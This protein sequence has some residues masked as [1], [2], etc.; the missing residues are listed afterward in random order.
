MKKIQYFLA[1]LFVVTL[2]YSGCKKDDNS[3]DSKP[4]IEVLGYTPVN[5]SLGLPYTDAGALVWDITID[6]DTIEITD[7]LVVNNP[8]DVN[9]AG[10]YHVTYNASDEAGNQA[11]ERKRTVNVVIGK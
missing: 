2:I 7:R 10:T 9:T 6:G 3:D 8:V 1:A 4:Y 5:H 11:D